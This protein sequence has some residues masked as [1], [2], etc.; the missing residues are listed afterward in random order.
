MIRIRNLP[1]RVIGVLA[2]KG[3][4]MVG[5]DQ[6]DTA[7]VPYTTVQKK[8]LGQQIPSINQAIISSISPEASAVTEK[9]ASEL[10]RQR[11]KIQ[12]GHTDD[13]MVRNMTDVAQSSVQITTMI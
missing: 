4:S 11:H 2:P 1:F 6:D 8:L 9:Q 10:L 12:P 5:Q 7:V 13:I 3:Q